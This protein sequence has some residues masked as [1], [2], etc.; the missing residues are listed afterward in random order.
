MHASDPHLAVDQVPGL[1]YLAGLHSEEGLD[2]VGVTYGGGPFV[3]MGHN[4][5]IAFSFTVA[6]VDVIDYVGDRPAFFCDARRVLRPGGRLFTV[7]DSEE[8]IARRRPLSSHFP[9]T[10][11]VELA[12]YPRMAT[13]RSELEGAGFDVSE[14]Q[15][16]LAYR[17]T[18]VE[19]YRVRAFSALGVIPEDSFRRGLERLEAELAAGAVPA[20]S[21]Y[22]LL[23]AHRPIHR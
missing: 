18:D 4:R 15:V 5:E 12:R 20:L 9:E 6:S 22:T 17:L 21:L 8:D 16:E 11:A 2:V 19:P 7:T 13:L 10:V 1:W 14:Q 3:V 23:W